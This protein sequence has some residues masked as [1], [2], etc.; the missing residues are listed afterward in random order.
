MIPFNYA[1]LPC[2]QI[3]HSRPNLTHMSLGTLQRKTR[4]LRTWHIQNLRI[5]V[6]ASHKNIHAVWPDMYLL[7]SNGCDSRGPTI[8]RQ[9]N[10]AFGVQVWVGILVPELLTLSPQPYKSGLPEF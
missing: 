3:V 9:N 10:A 7:G 2:V 1:S 6:S 5:E 8:L 4:T